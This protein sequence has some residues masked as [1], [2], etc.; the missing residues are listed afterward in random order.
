[1]TFYDQCVA[2]VG[3]YIPAPEVFLNRQLI[4]HLNKTKDT[5]SV[6]DKTELAKWC[7]VSAGLLVGNEKAEALSND[8]LALQ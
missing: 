6:A 2:L 8:I 1:M 4:A 7:K 3:K 5:L